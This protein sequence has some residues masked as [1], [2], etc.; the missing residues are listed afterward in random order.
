MAGRYRTYWVVRRR[1]RLGGYAASILSTLVAAI[2]L[3][4][5]VH[6]ADASS[7]VGQSSSFGGTIAVLVVAAIIPPL[8]ARLLWRIHRRRY[9]DDIYPLG[10]V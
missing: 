9:L 2:Y 7:A 10:I 5:L 4:P 1:Y 3:V 8:T 6:S